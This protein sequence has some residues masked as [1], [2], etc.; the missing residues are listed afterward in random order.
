MSKDKE[1]PLIEHLRE[2]K[3]RV[4]VVMISF[5]VALIFWMAFPADLTEILRNPESYAPIAKSLV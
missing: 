5:V 1:M 2:L 4:K 3:N